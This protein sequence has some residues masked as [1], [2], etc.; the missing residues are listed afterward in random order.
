MICWAI[1]KHTFGYNGK[2][3]FWPS[4]E[5]K[6]GL[7]SYAV[8]EMWDKITVFDGVIDGLKKIKGSI[9]FLYTG[10]CYCYTKAGEVSNIFQRQ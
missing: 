10:S 2:K 7:K 4:R 8:W 9:V 5:T 6:I 1:I 3:I